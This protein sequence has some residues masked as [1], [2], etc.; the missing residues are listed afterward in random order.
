MA[1]LTGSVAI[2]QV[3]GVARAANTVKFLQSFKRL[4]VFPEHHPAYGLA[5]GRLVAKTL[6]H[7]LKG[8]RLCCH[9]FHLRAVVGN[10]VFQPLVDLARP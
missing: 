3:F 7:A 10:G 2:L 1:K 5:G 6:R 4:R 9:A 8:F